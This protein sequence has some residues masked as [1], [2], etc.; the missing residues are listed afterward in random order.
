[1]VSQL[2]NG[3]ILW[4]GCNNKDFVPMHTVIEG[5]RDID[6]DQDGMYADLK[7]ANEFSFTIQAK[8]KQY[9]GIMDVMMGKDTSAARRCIR[10][11]KAHEGKEK[12]EQI[13]AWKAMRTL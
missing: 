1:M 5:K 4:L 6:Y 9:K 3:T 11:E 7:R 13:K 10:H 12:E 8:V 2:D